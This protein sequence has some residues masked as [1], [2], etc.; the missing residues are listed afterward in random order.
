MLLGELKNDGK[1]CQSATTHQGWTK[2]ISTTTYGMVNYFLIFETLSL[3]Y[4]YF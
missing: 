1:H 2:K 3:P 4:N